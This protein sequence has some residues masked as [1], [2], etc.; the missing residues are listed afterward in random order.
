LNNLS[1]PKKVFVYILIIVLS[2]PVGGALGG[3]LGLVATTFVPQ[4]CTDAGCHNCFQFKGMVGYEATG[5]LGFWSGLFLF[6]VI[7]TLVIF[8]RSRKNK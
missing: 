8:Y 6:P 4:C 3:F 1:K 5:Y 2:L 7:C